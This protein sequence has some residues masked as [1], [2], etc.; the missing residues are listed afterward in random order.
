MKLINT[1]KT[2]MI[3]ITTYLAEQIHECFCRDYGTNAGCRCVSRCSVFFWL[4]G[5][6]CCLK[7]KNGAGLIGVVFIAVET[8]AFSLLVLSVAAEAVS[9]TL[10]HLF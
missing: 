7:R 8:V 5:L 2:G 1:V 6:G 9:V 4:R 3:A 10:H